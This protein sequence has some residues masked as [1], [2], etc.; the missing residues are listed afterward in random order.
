MSLESDSC[1]ENVE[2][3][4]SS[5][6]ASVVG[7]RECCGICTGLRSQNLLWQVMHVCIL[8]T[9][10]ERGKRGGSLGPCPVGPFEA[11]RQP[12]CK[13]ARSVPCGL[14]EL[15]ETTH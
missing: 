15:L 6:T 10:R 11:A 8:C 3:K 13:E 1:P 4:Q 7:P 2:G 9:L 14:R 12:Q 5:L